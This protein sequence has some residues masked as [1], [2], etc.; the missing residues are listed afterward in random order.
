M[1]VLV[2]DPW[3]SDKYAV[4][5]KG[6]CD[7]LSKVVDLTLC[8]S[9]YI[10][11][12]SQYKIMPYFF[13]WSDKMKR[14]KIRAIVRGVEYFIAYCRIIRL[15][16]KENYDVI[17]IEWALMHGLDNFFLKRMKRYT[18]KLVY[19]SHNVLPHIDGEKHIDELKVLHSKFDTI[20]VHGES[21]KEEYLKYF[22]EDISKLEI[23]YHGVHLSQKLTFD[24][25]NVSNELIKFIDDCPGRIIAFVGI[26]FYNK[27]ADRVIKYWIQ[28]HNTTDDRLIVAGELSQNYSELNSL[29]SEVE[30]SKTIFYL[31]RYLNEDEYSYV[32]SK[33]DIVTIP[34]RHASSGIV[35]SAAAFTKPI[36]YT[37]TG[38]INEYVG[39]QGGL[40]S[41]ND[42]GELYH[43]LDEV[44]SWDN[45]TVLK[46]GK[47]LHERIYNEYDWDRIAQKLVREI[48]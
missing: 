18:N 36:L 35:Y 10:T 8:S 47:A 1:K 3:C 6:L 38:A 29:M 48:Y 32:L 37:N 31:P 17:H 9:F 34:Y 30:N 4:Y 25:K 41:Q 46:K 21:I 43:C 5:T 11:E 7:G 2:I 23:Q 13:V 45:D 14:G 44:L 16:K 27:G 39:E 12:S 40:C 26:I 28:N 42:D 33:T 24:L 22:P 15:I 19:T 20:L